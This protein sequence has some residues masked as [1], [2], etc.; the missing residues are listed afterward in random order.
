MLNLDLAL[1]WPLSSRFVN[2]KSWH[3]STPFANK[4]WELEISKTTDI[5]SVEFS[6]SLLSQTD[7]AGVR[8]G[9]GL[10]GYNLGFSFYDSRHRDSPVE[11]LPYSLW[12]VTFYTKKEDELVVARREVCYNVFEAEQ[13]IA[14]EGYQ[15]DKAVITQG[16]GA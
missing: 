2:L 14:D 7:H 12:T 5:V 15:Y 3:G 6:V 16:G 8:F 1:R 11:Q 13:L 4:H 10:L 9:V